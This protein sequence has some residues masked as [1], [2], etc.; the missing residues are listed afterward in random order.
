ML[1]RILLLAALAT[2]AS[3]PTTTSAQTTP[4]WIEL[5]VRDGPAASH[6][7]P[8]RISVPVPLRS[9]S[10]LET[11][12]GAASYRVTVARESPDQPGTRLHFDIRRVDPRHDG[13]HDVSLSV[14]VALRQGHRATLARF[15]RPDGT[16]TELT[17]RLTR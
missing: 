12:V 7:D 11:R 6:V 1:R 9:A 4:H 13:T 16:R 2:F 5:E 8:V 14:S 10:T 17:A 3:L 15:E